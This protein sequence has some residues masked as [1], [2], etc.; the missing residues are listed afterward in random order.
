MGRHGP[1]H[2]TATR[3]LHAVSVFCRVVRIGRS[4]RIDITKAGNSQKEVPSPTAILGDGDL[5]EPG[6]FLV[7]YLNV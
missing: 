7:S 3:V 1:R 4:G 2:R 6:A 5:V